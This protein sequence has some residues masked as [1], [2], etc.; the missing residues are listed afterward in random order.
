MCL[1]ENGKTMEIAYWIV[2]GLLALAVL[3]AGGMKLARPKEALAA[4]GM[5]WV[6]DFGG[7]TVKLI[8]AAEVLGAIGL[9]LPKLTGIAPILSPIAALALAV[10]MLGAIVVHVRRKE[11]FTPSLVLGLLAVAAA[12]LG[13]LTLS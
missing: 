3:A 4:S 9:I 10:T 13:F 6:S 2:A 7:G 11:S 8:G 1:K 5:G 12:I